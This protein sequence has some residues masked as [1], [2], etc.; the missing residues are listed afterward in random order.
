MEKEYK[1]EMKPSYWHAIISSGQYSDYTEEHL[2]FAGNTAEEV[3]NFLCR[4][5]E[6]LYEGGQYTYD[7]LALKW[8]ETVYISPKY[9]GDKEAV[10]YTHLTLPTIYSV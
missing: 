2:F 3:W 4:Y 6:S 7:V 5:K 8:N 9:T 10:S 1:I